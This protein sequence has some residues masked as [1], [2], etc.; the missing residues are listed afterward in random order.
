MPADDHDGYGDDVLTDDQDGATVSRDL[1]TG[2]PGSSE[3]VSAAD[4]QSVRRPGPARHT[5]MASR[6]ANPRLW[7]CMA[8]VLTL[9]AVTMS[10]ALG[11]H[12]RHDSRLDVSDEGAHYSYVVSLRSGHIPAWGDTLTVGERRLDDCLQAIG[13]PPAPCKSTP[14]PASQ[15]PAGG[16]DYEAQQPPLGYLPYVLTANPQA[17]PDAAIAAARHGG[18]IWI[19]ISGALLLVLAALE[20]FS[21]LG[22]S[23]LLASCLFNPVFTYAAA[24]VTNDAA[25][26]AAGAVGLLAWSLSRKRPKWGLWFGLAAG[27]LLGLTKGITVVVPLALVVVAIMDSGRLLLSWAGIWEALRRHMCAIAMLGATVITYGAFIMIQSARATV[28]SS[29]VLHDLLGITYTAALQPSTISAGVTATLT[30]FQPNYRYDALNAVWGLGAFGVLVGVWLLRVPAF[31]AARVRGMSL[32]I[33]VG[34]LALIV[35]WPLL[36]FIQGHY[37]FSAAVRYDVPLLPLI[38]YVIVMGCRRFGVIAVGVALPVACAILQLAI[39]KY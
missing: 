37:N 24:T 11:G 36:T 16:Y 31:V 35:G 32:G 6:A 21:L 17:P 12:R 14:P 10:I 20:D 13:V 5:R 8:I 1:A 3:N 26:V 19:A 7:W 4:E 38:A 29:V 39:T 2:D 15:Y 30:L 18:M 23:A 9:A 33:L 27:V 25:G 28:P 22:L 34:M